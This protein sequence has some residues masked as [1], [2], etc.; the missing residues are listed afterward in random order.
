MGKLSQIANAT[1]RQSELEH[2]LEL[3]DTLVLFEGLADSYP[4]IRTIAARELAHH[5]N[6]E[7][8]AYLRALV[9]GDEA[10]QKAA[11]IGLAAD[12]FLK[13][14]PSVQSA[15]C[16]ALRGSNDPASAAVL[17]DAARSEDAD[18]R[19]HALVSLHHLPVPEGQLR[20]LVEERLSDED[21]E[22]AII[23]AQLTAEAGWHEL[24]P[25]LDGLRLRLEGRGDLQVTFA[26]AELIGKARK[27][28][29]D[30]PEGF[31]TPIVE[32]CIQALDDEAT[33]AA[34]GQ[35]LATLGDPRATRALEQVLDKWMTHPILKVGA[36]AALVELGHE[37]GEQYLAEMLESRRKD[38]RG[39]ALRMIGKLH[40]TKHLPEL[41]KIAK[42]DDYHADTAVLALG[43]MGGER[44]FEVLH[45]I[46]A[47]HGDEEIREL[48][49]QCLYGEERP[50]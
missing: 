43:D 4:P 34:A 38:A 22:V 7:F 32:Q 8:E 23:A 14:S 12:D 17:V 44:A 24:L 31:I 15:A 25:R 18:L 3:G 49:N 27:S 40:M 41:I 35:A 16:V 20:P 21:P 30:L 1:T 46:A 10:F 36:A 5:L 37:R 29:T 6:P 2:R 11:D 42:S 50:A 39:Y 33:T 13:P 9:R 47:E 48:A 45:E 28:G 19:Y 26:I